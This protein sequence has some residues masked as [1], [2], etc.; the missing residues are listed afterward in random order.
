M[1]RRPAAAERRDQLHAGGFTDLVTGGGATAG[2]A[3]CVSTAIMTR[4]GRRGSAGTRRGTPALVAS[5][6]RGSRVQV[7]LGDGQVG[8]AEYP[9]QIGHRHLRAVRHPIRRGVTQIVRRP[10]PP[11]PRWHG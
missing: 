6:D 3:C 5:P 4:P 11:T 10:M 8:V 7:A 9:L 1:T 2:A